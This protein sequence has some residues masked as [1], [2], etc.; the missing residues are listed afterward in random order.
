MYF[1]KFP[2]IV[3]SMLFISLRLKP[4]KC[5]KI[6][7]KEISFTDSNNLELFCVSLC[8]NQ[9]SNFYKKFQEES[10]YDIGSDYKIWT[11]CCDLILSNKVTDT[12][13]YLDSN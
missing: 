7:Y 6:H 9:L 10:S 5:I 13:I 1:Q 8:T 12:G 11:S 2:I 3:C 4:S